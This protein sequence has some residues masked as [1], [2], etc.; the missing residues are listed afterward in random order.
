MNNV[1]ILK[2]LA[3]G[4]NANKQTSKKYDCPVP[5]CGRTRKEKKI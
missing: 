3:G 1:N 4:A 2:G 5:N